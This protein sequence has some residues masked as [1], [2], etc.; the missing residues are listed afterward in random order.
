MTADDKETVR[1]LLADRYNDWSNGEKKHLH[2]EK[3]TAR[4]FIDNAKE[5]IATA[6]REI[7]D[8]ELSI[9]LLSLAS[10]HD[11][12]LWDLSDNLPEAEWT[13]V[14]TDEEFTEKA[15]SLGISEDDIAY[16]VKKANKGGA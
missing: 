13:F 9:G 16:Y 3:S 1:K 4:M 8:A 12:K 5:R 2:W 15:R 11:F 7:Q 10:I 14:G 6:K